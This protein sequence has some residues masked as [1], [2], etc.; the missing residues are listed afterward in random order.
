MNYSAAFAGAAVGGIGFGALVALASFWGKRIWRKKVRSPQLGSELASS[1]LELT[2]K[3]DRPS[4]CFTASQTSLLS[5][6]RELCSYSLR[7]ACDFPSRSWRTQRSSRGRRRKKSITSDQPWRRGRLKGEER[8]CFPS[9]NH[10]ISS[11]RVLQRDEIA[12]EVVIFSP[13]RNRKEEELPSP[14]SP[15]QT[16]RFAFLD[17][18]RQRDI[19]GTDMNVILISPGARTSSLLPQRRSNFFFFQR[20]AFQSTTSSQPR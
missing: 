2:S 1:F 11:M 7:G 18:L 6:R 5:R 20:V 4:F 3:F 17:P 16:P 15:I 12:D 10:T 8:L 14:S 19:R 13:K 9:C